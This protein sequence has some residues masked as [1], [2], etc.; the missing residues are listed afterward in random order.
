MSSV[1]GHHSEKLTILLNVNAVEDTSIDNS[2]SVCYDRQED[3]RSHAKP[4]SLHNR[5]RVRDSWR[6]SRNDPD[7]G[8]IWPNSVTT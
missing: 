5:Y 8:E 3:R 7:V 1:I 2:N 4:S 6:A